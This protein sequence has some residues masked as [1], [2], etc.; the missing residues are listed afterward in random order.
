MKACLGL[1]PNVPQVAVFDTSFYSD[2]EDFRYIY[3]IPYEFYEKYQVR[4]Y[5]FHGTSHRY[6]SAELAKTLGKDPKELKVITCHLGNGSSVTAVDGGVAI[7]TS[8][9]F[10]PQEGIVMGTR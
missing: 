7:D 8:M 4:R 5:G 6:V 2:I 1:M 10:T 3:P 9:G